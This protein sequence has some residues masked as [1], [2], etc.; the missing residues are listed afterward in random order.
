MRTLTYFWVSAHLIT[1]LM[2]ETSPNQSENL[3]WGFILH[4]N[5]AIDFFSLSPLNQII[6]MDGKGCCI[7]CN[8]TEQNF[9]TI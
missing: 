7:C 4:N 9:I 2:V 1:F 3:P 8:K 6:M 5:L